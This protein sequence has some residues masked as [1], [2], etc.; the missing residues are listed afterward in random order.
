MKLSYFGV[1]CIL[2]FVTKSAFCLP[3]TPP[4]HPVENKNQTKS[5][6]EGSENLEV[7]PVFS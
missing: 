5:E 2:I 4:K 6:N 1:T 3:V 7:R